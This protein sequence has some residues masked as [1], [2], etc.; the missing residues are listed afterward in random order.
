MATVKGLIEELQ[1]LD[2]D[3]RIHLASDPEGNTVYELDEIS[4]DEPIEGEPRTVTLWPGRKVPS[5]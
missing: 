2:P 4:E 5:V 3:T 1:A